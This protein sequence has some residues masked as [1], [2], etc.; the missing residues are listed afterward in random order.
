MSM[1]D[2]EL[3]AAL[4]EARRSAAGVPDRIREIGRSA[5]AWRTVD[6]E[7]AALSTEAPAGARAEPAAVRALTFAARAVTIE[8]EVTDEALHGQVVPPRPGEI[9]LH[10]RTGVVAVAQVDEVGWFVL[11]PVPRGMFRL[12]LRAGG[13]LVVT[14]WVTI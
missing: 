4:A 8:V 13:T 6:A 9:E 12:H 5:F 11:S 7:L 2:E 3:L 14:E 1:N 10:D